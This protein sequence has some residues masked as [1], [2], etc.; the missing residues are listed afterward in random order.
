MI[1][2]GKGSAQVRGFGLEDEEIKASKII[3]FCRCV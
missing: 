1:F 3:G 2:M